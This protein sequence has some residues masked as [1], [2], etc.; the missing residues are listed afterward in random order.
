MVQ[1][2][3]VTNNAPE[4]FESVGHDV[5]L[6]GDTAAIASLGRVELFRRNDVGW[7]NIA[8]L[9]SKTDF[10]F[11]NDFG[12]SIA[13]DG[14][15]L[16]VLGNNNVYVFRESLEPALNAWNITD[17]TSGSGVFHQY[18]RPLDPRAHALAANGGWTLTVKGRM[19]DDFEG[20]MSCFVEFATLTE[21]FLLYFDLD[22][23][24]NLVASPYGMEPITLTSDGAGWAQYHLHEA[25][26]DP[27][28]GTADYYF[29]GVTMN[30]SPW[31]PVPI[32]GLDG[33]RFGNGA[34]GGRGSMNWHKVELVT[35]QT[36]AVLASY[37]AHTATNSPSDLDPV[38]QG[39]TFAPGN[40]GSG[41]S[42]GPVRPDVL[43]LWK[44]EAILEASPEF[45]PIDLE[46]DRLVLGDYDEENAAW[47]LNYYE[48]VGGAWV[49]RQVIGPPFLQQSASF[50]EAGSLSGDRLAMTDAGE[51]RAY[52]YVLEDGQW[53][54]EAELLPDHYLGIHGASIDITGNR[55]VLGASHLPKETGL[56]EVILFERN[57]AE[58]VE[59]ERFSQ[60]GW[61][62]GTTAAVEGDTVIIGRSRQ[63][64]GAHYI[65]TPDGKSEWS[66]VHTR[67]YLRKE[68][69]IP[70]PV[71]RDVAIDGLNILVGVP[72]VEVQSGAGYFYRLDYGNVAGLEKYLRKQLDFDDAKESQSYDPYQAA[73]R[74]KHLLYRE[75]TDGDI[76]ARF[77]TIDEFYGAAELENSRAV[78]SELIKG[79]AL[80]PD[81]P[82]LGNLLL[83]IY[84]DRTVAS[85]LLGRPVT[86]DAEYARFGLS[87]NAPLPPN[88]FLI[89]VE[90]PL[91]RQVL[92]TNRNVLN[93]YFSLLTDD[94]GLSSE[95]PLSYRIFQNRVPSRALGSLTTT[96]A[97][98]ETVPVTSDPVLFDGYKD[99]VLL[100]QLLRDHGQSA[101]TLARLLIGRDSPGDRDEAAALIAGT[102]RF[103][104]LH[105]ETLNG[106]FET[107][108]PEER[109]FRPRECDPRL[110][111]YPR[112]AHLP[113]TG[114]SRKRQSSRVCGRFH[115]VCSKVQPAGR[116]YGA[117]PQLAFVRGR[118]RI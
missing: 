15:T 96:N 63:D 25:V 24:K 34:T 49:P 106:M 12:E 7:T 58:W 28:S 8:I 30:P 27:D 54:F 17:Q 102:Q 118:R 46:G 4:N 10:S 89:D 55:V 101:E 6:S 93:E 98:G 75:E 16:A 45:I 108:P 105:G 47:V 84:Y 71:V 78:E 36:K 107:L 43:T 19:V 115:D 111:G 38:L 14:D 92:E 70:D 88:G 21:R 32:T 86:E 97:A 85:V 18:R 74:Y 65:Y 29:D 60:P 110:G 66:L 82:V 117:Y 113:R 81:D 35:T 51:D 72:D 95:P 69:G 22:D 2:A 44:P 40:P 50:G 87:L 41:I 33:V 37:K 103:L 76:R 100:F 53:V 109:S 90:T 61:G 59:F 73:F 64:P 3:R 23:N 104:L 11:P 1:K 42:Q 116:L 114:P 77:D 112:R 20:T 9:S 99:L 91:Y 31:S 80:K 26:F 57:G 79:L 67:E 39:W 13:L 52:I 56:P 68:E 62:F 83:D 94:L 48:R 5:E